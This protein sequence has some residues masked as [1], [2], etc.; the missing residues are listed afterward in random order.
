[1]ER[2]LAELGFK[3]HPIFGEVKRS[4]APWRQAAKHAR[5]HVDARRG[6]A[7]PIM[8][9]FKLASRVKHEPTI[10]DVDGIKIGERNRNNAVS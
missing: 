2:K 9:P 8:K 6:D 3:T 1:M 10:V 5:H 7:G 4:L